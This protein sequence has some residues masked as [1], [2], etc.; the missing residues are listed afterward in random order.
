MP[1][2][3]GNL[4]ESTFTL[5]KLYEAYLV[6]RKGK[7]NTTAV[8]EFETDLGYNLKNLYDELHNGTYQPKPYRQFTIKE[9]K[10]RLI[11]A[12]SFRDVVVQHA[13][14][15]VINPIF[16]K[17]FIHDNYGCRLNKGTHKASSQAQQYLRKSSKDMYFMQLDIRKFY[18][19]IDRSILKQLLAKKIKDTRF[20]NLLVKFSDHGEPIGIPIGNLL[21]QLYALVYLHELDN[22]VKR[23]LKIKYYVRYVDDFILFNLSKEECY[24]ILHDIENFLKISL[25]LSLSRY[26]IA[27]ISKGVNFV[28]F[29]TWR[30]VKFVRKHS[31]YKFSVSLKNEDVVSLQ[32]ILGNAKHSSSYK[33]LCSRLLNESP[34]IY[35]KLVL[36]S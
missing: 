10:T 24:K 19:S 20:L 6:A 15:A 13:I 30:N 21:S 18:Y 3:I 29:R 9:P 23:V 25:K 36:R 16:D 5:E 14:Y 31:L 27:K 28:G 11:S 12:P 22:Y 26:T 32:S 4:F 2:R 34:H 1:K 35:S 8:F 33:H 7:R 17:T